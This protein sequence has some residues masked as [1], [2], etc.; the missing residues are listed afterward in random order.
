VLAT[1]PGSQACEAFYSDGG[2][3]GFSIATEALGVTG[4]ATLASLTPAEPQ[5]ITWSNGEQT[6]LS[7]GIEASGDG[8]FR[9]RDELPLELG[10]GPSVSYPV[11]IKLKSADGRL[12]GAYPG[13]VVATGYGANR[14]VTADAVLELALNE[15]GESGFSSVSVPASADSLMLRVET[16]LE[17]G[18]VA[19]S[20]RLQALTDADCASEPST[21]L[22]GGAQGSP[23][24]AGQTQTPIESASWSH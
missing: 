18:I 14:T 15:V 17:A 1:W 7:I 9:V 11:V 20:V 22:P 24:C 3:L 8:C 21:P 10:G 19:G 2:G 12:D 4:E 23:G 6:T 13:Q 16:T 5:P